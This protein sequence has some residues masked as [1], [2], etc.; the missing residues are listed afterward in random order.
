MNFWLVKTEP[1]TYSWKMFIDK[2]RDHWDGVRN[3]Q[4]RNN[5]KT[6]KTGDK[7]LFYHSGKERAVVGLARVIREAYPDPTTSDERWVAVDLE[8]ER[9][10]KNPVS[11]QQ[12]KSD[13][14]LER[15]ALVRHSRLS[16]MPLGEDEFHRIISMEN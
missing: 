9:P 6:M 4:A 11:L 1:E 3:F 5:L 13:P 12:I 15:I 8:P 2:G 7:V 10:L 14:A 16:V